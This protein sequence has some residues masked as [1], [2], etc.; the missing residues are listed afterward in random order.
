MPVVGQGMTLSYSLA[1]PGND[2]V[3]TGLTTAFLIS[4]SYAAGR[5]HQFF[6]QATDRDNAFRDGYDTA[7]HSLFSMATRVA[8]YTITRP[9]IEATPVPIRAQVPPVTGK[10][11]RARHRASDRRR[12]ELAKTSR[13]SYGGQ[14]Q[15]S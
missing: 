13:M 12:A 9:A 8:R 15:A 14:R 3:L 5:V 2:V 6:K 10:P 1:V 11:G 4:C 7:A